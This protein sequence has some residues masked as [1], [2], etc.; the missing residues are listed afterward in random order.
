MW[1]PLEI[2][3]LMHSYGCRAPF[4]EMGLEVV[5]NAHE[6]LEMNDLILCEDRGDSK[7]YL[8]TE[9]GRAMVNFIL[10]MPTP[11]EVFLNPQTTETFN[12]NE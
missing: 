4:P 3:I 10:R 6:K 1:S 7:I 12:P 8:T 5:A 2:K 11:V 9:R